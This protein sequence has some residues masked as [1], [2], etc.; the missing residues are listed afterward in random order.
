MSN[1]VTLRAPDTALNDVPDGPLRRAPEFLELEAEILRLNKTT[2]RPWPPRT[3]L[4]MPTRG[5]PKTS[6]YEA[7]CTR[8]WETKF[9]RFGHSLKLRSSATPHRGPFIRLD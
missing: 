1:A 7:N 2:E 8:S 5:S 4:L 3:K 9:P 6:L